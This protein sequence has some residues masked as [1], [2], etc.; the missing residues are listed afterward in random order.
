V[1]SGLPTTGSPDSG[2]ENTQALIRQGSG[3]N[4]CDW[5]LDEPNLA[6]PLDPGSWEPGSSGARGV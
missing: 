4:T 2:A 6:R 1:G 5:L 3:A